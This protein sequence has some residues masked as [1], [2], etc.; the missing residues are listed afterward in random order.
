MLA[1]V[2]SIP[3]WSGISVHQIVGHRIGEPSH[4]IVAREKGI[5]VTAGRANH[6]VMDLAGRAEMLWRGEQTFSQY[7]TP[8]FLSEAP[9]VSSGRPRFCRTPLYFI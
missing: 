9:L 7:I 6:W 3:A 5:S 4:S 8:S 1:S 2:P